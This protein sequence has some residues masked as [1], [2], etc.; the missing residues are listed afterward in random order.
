[1]GTSISGGKLE[2]F[3]IQILDEL[4]L[5]WIDISH[6]GHTFTTAELR[7]FGSMVPAHG[8]ERCSSRLGHGEF[9]G[10]GMHR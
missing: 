6:F 10:E 7:E 3:E 8:G 9:H 2:E 4:E 5:P 1:M